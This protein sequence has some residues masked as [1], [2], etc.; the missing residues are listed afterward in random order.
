[1]TNGESASVDHTTVDAMAKVGQRASMAALLDSL[2]T[3]EEKN[4]IVIGMSA[5][6]KGRIDECETCLVAGFVEGYVA[7][8]HL[9][10]EATGEVNGEAKVDEAVIAGKFSGQLV[11]SGRLQL[12]SGAIVTGEVSYAEIEIEAGA[13]LA[14]RVQTSGLRYQQS[15]WKRWASLR[16]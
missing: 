12:K 11:V 8:R 9:E 16:G 4:S 2:E 7:T 13:R 10:I 1:M 15:G 3:V 14:G 5:H 6:L